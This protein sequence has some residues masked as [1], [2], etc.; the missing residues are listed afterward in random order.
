MDMPRQ[1]PPH[2]HRETTRH[3]TTVWY[4]RVGKGP[5]IR[6]RAL[7]GSD[8]FKAEYAAAVA[9]DNA[10]SKGPENGT[11]QWLFDRYRETVAWSNLSLATRR[12]RENIFKHVMKASGREQFKRIRTAHI[13]AGRD[14]REKTP[15]QAR[16]FLDAMRGLF[17]WAKKAKFVAVDPTAGVENPERNDGH[18]FL[19]WSEEEVAK[20]EAHWPRGTRQ[21]VWFDV[22]LYTG[23]RRGDAVQLGRQHVK[24]GIATLQ[25][26]KGD[27]MVT[28]N[29]P[30]LEPL[31]R[32]LEAGPTGDMIFICGERGGPLTKESFGNLF[33][34]AC[35]AA[36]VDA[37]KKAAHGLRKA[38]AT[39]A[40]ENGATESELNA[41]FGWNDPKMAQ[42]YTK[43]ANKKRLALRAMRKLEKNDTE[44][45]TPAPQVP[46]RAA[47]EK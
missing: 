12:Q 40:A 7:Y 34:K 27:E 11:L 10:K 44:T 26:E 28:V 23:L 38:G 1:R 2:L 21:R 4:V 13:E 29:L 19:M 42:H 3:G 17:R 24:D 36:G 18:G 5:R 33:K 15:A 41:I 30:I 25:L 32:T 46:V 43:L 20:Y 31:K 16:N 45:A 22:L 47:S 39:R 37:K 14:R 8:E 6:I 9:G 35:K